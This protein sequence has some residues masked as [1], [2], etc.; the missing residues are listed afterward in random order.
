M[1][2]LSVV[3]GGGRP[4]A[5]PE[6]PLQSRGFFRNVDSWD[7]RDQ[8]L[9]VRVVLPA[10][11]GENIENGPCKTFGASIGGQVPDLEEHEAHE[12]ERGLD[13]HRPAGVTHA[14][15]DTLEADLLVRSVGRIPAI[16]AC[17]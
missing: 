11:G 6:L 10:V 5:L 13:R 17:L 3:P 16:R 14:A 1:E 2:R 7:C 12:V 4:S 8:P 15:E 9:G